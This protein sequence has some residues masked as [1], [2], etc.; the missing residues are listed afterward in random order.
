[1]ATEVGDVWKRLW[2]YESNLLS[3]NQGY[4]PGHPAWDDAYAALTYAIERGQERKMVMPPEVYKRLTAHTSNGNIALRDVWNG[5]NH[6]RPSEVPKLLVNW[7][8]TARQALESDSFKVEQEAHKRIKKLHYDLMRIRP[9]SIDNERLARIMAVNL[10]LYAGVDPLMFMY[11]D[12]DW[13]M[14]ALLDC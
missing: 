4:Q 13:Y 6:P 2:V 3:Y 7:V 8:V 11:E 14:R 10:C 12:K 5:N 9:Y 1:M